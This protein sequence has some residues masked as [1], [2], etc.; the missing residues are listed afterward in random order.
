YAAELERRGLAALGPGGGEL[1]AAVHQNA[2][3]LVLAGRHML[4]QHDASV[5][6]ALPTIAVPTLVIV[7][8]DDKPFRKGATYMAD[9]IPDA[10]LVVVPG[11]GHS[12]NV[13]HRDAFDAAL[14]SFLDGVRVAR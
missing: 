8:E 12:P 4:T 3:G 7:G 5:L 13:T 10:T 1:S 9:K 11:A 2:E 6:D 14:R